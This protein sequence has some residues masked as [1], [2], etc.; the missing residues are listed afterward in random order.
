MRP[1]GTY[2]NPNFGGDDLDARLRLEAAGIPGV[3]RIFYLGRPNLRAVAIKQMSPTHVDDIVR[4]LVPGG[5]QYMGHH[6][7][8]LVDDDIDI[9][10][11]EE[12]LWAVAGR[13]APEMGVQVIPGTAVWQLDPRLRPEDRSDPNQGEGRKR[14]TAHNLVINACRPYDWIEQFP[15]VAVNGPDLRRRIQ[16][17]WKS[18]LE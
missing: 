1:I 3:Q 11:P 18:I 5:D 7:W 13:C 2:N 10:R 15:P 4:V 6:I 16:E 17:K 12:V 9:S 8:V 14:Y